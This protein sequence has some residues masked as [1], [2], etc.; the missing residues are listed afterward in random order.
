MNLNEKVKKGQKERT[1]SPR[2]FPNV[3]ANGIERLEMH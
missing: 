1:E 3:A 2:A